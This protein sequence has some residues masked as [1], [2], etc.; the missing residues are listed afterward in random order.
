MLE[1]TKLWQ[2]ITHQ[3]LVFSINAAWCLV[4]DLLQ[5]E[6]ES[7]VSA[8]SLISVYVR[9]SP[10]LLPAQK[11]K[12]VWQSTVSSKLKLTWWETA[13][14]WSRTSC[15]KPFS[16]T[17]MLWWTCSTLLSG[18]LISLVWAQFPLK[19]TCRIPT[20]MRDNSEN[21]IFRC[22]RCRWPAYWNVYLKWALSGSR[23]AVV[24]VSDVTSQS[25]LQKQE[26]RSPHGR[27]GISS[28]IILKTTT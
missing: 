11:K 5:I 20:Y 21:F 26:P 27:G 6:P 4:S 19:S 16:F 24:H 25:D 7:L 28:T 10:L 9:V 12:T 8:W 3:R 13:W 22:C 18:F 15:V 1:S 17:H 14:I 2:K 23:S